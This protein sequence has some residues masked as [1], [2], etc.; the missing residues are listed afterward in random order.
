M[1]FSFIMRVICSFTSNN[2][3]MAIPDISSI[4][5]TSTM[6][7]FYSFGFTST[8]SLGKKG[9]DLFKKLRQESHEST[10]PSNSKMFLI[11]KT[12]STFS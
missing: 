5:G 3:V 2:F 1:N 9:M 8:F 11:P 6:I 7:S 4:N 10:T 12:K